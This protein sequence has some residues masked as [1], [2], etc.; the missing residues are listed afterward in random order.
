MQID[1]SSPVVSLIHGMKEGGKA[2]QSQTADEPNKAP[3]NESGDVVTVTD[4]AAYMQHI[5]EVITS[6]PVINDKRVERV[7][8][9]VNDGHLKNDPAH[10]AARILSF[11]SALNSARRGI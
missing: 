8:Q 1:N 2:Q 3:L 7:Q 9:V 10:L 6:Q 5:E 4:A 11:E